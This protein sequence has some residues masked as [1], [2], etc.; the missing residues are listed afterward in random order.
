MVA[1]VARIVFH[2]FSR[3]HAEIRPSLFSRRSLTQRR[4]FL[5]RSRNESAKAVTKLFKGKFPG[6]DSLR[7]KAS[8][9]RQASQV[10]HESVEP[11]ARSFDF[12]HRSLMTKLILRRIDGFERNWGAQTSGFSH[13]ALPKPRR[14]IPGGRIDRRRMA[15]QQMPDAPAA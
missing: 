5:R 14:S 11:A 15:K 8:S 3:R 4:F 12:A 10:R 13:Q 7:L 9:L 2:R 6:G 1:G